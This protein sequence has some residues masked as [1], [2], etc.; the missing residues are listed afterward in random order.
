MLSKII[1]S[2]SLL[3]I[4]TTSFA[5]IDYDDINLEELNIQLAKYPDTILLDIRDPQEL[6]ITGTINHAKNY[7]ISRGWLETRIASVVPD[8][9]TPVVT[10]C[11]QNIRSPLAAETL[12]SM[13]Y[14]NVTNFEDGIFKW[15]EAGQKMYYY[16]TYKESPLYS[17]PIKIIDDV[18]SAI[19]ATQ[20]GSSE[21][22]GHNN[23]L[24]YIIGDDGILVFNAG[25]SY[26]LAKA[27][28]E[29]IKKVSNLPIKF[30]VYE[31]TQGHAI[32]GSPY[33]KEQG[34][35]IIAHE[36]AT[37]LLHNPT[38][39]TDRAKRFLGNKYFMSD[40]LEADIY[41]DEYYKVP[42]KGKNIEIL[43]LG[44]AHGDDELLLWMP[45]QKLV[46]T[47]DF[48]FNERM[49]PVL[50]TTDINAWLESWPRLIELN[51]EYIIPGHGGPTD[52][53]TITHY[54]KDYI[55]F[56][57]KSIENLIDD[58]G[59]ILD[60]YNIDDSGFLHFGLYKLLSTQNLV[61]I[62]KKFEFEY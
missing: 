44:P 20:P 46:I 56:L 50:P 49:L 18:Y 40:A 35:K 11:G 30:V 45:D 2:A 27:L 14:T 37:E 60:V 24:S 1:I 59:E 32:L 58:D 57:K 7:N 25:G 16:D 19:G 22:Y 48:A 61:S 23:N 6:K 15:E 33:W 39:T 9:D 38:K 3:F 29:E 28:H 31:N 21:N 54:T 51:P 8:Y 47:G 4:Q 62:F 53:K 55:T 10:Y 34:A 36:N 41:V 26:I 5:E 43:H 42:L 17:K 12:I 52:I 13:G